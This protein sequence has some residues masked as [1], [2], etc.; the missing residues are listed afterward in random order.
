MITHP[1]YTQLPLE[2]RIRLETGCKV[3]IYYRIYIL[4]VIGYLF[5]MIKMINEVQERIKECEAEL[6]ALAEEEINQII[7]GTRTDISV[8]GYDKVRSEMKS[9]EFITSRIIFGSINKFNISLQ[10]KKRI[11]KHF[12]REMI[13]KSESENPYHDFNVRNNP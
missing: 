2:Y 13:L 1:L 11:L 12:F 3:I 5:V 4:E 7:K 6:E 8:T 9:V 10:E